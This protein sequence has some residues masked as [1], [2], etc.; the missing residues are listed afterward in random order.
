M[1]TAHHYFYRRP[2]HRWGHLCHLSKG[3][4]CQPFP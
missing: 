2:G 3:E 4:Q 1:S